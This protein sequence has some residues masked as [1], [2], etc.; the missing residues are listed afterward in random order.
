[1]PKGNF[2]LARFRNTTR[3]SDAESDPF[4]RGPIEAWLLDTIPFGHHSNGQDGCLFASQFRDEEGECIDTDPDGPRVVNKKDGSFSTNYIEI[5][6]HYWR[7]HL[8]SDGAAAGDYASRWEWRVGGGVQLNPEGYVGGAIKP[9]LS[10]LYGPTRILFS[11]MFARRDA[12]RCGRS[13]VDAKFQYLTEP[14]PDVPNVIS[15]VEGTCFPRSWGGA[16]LFLRYYHGQD[17]YN[18]GF[19]ESINRLQFGV[20]L[21]QDGFLSFRIKPL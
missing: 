6:L 21:Q 17:Y 20:T 13:T 12:W 8:D 7:M 19:D 2:Q 4:N 18:L 1:M 5:T 16:G 14:P 15:Q 9:E 10:E 11:G 3:E